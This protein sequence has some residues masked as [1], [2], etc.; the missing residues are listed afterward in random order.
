MNKP[1]NI[2]LDIVFILAFSN[3]ILMTTNESTGKI[4][5]EIINNIIIKSKS[6]RAPI[7]FLLLIYIFFFNIYP[8]LLLDQH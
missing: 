7:I 5:Q 1:L 6:S 4:N 2:N 3:M 8:D